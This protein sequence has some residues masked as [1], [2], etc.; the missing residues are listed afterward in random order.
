MTGKTISRQKRLQLIAAAILLIGLASA[1]MIYFAAVNAE[2]RLM[3]TPSESKSY[4]H[5]LELYGGKMN[6]LA[7]DLLRG[8]ASLWEGKRLAY[9][10]AWVSIL[11]AGVMYYVSR[12][13]RSDDQKPG[14][15]SS[16]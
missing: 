15:R 14:E 8:V 11:I 7:N 13:M 4:R 1:I 9:T 2:A 6:L 16:R 10:V 12:H 5:G 3:D